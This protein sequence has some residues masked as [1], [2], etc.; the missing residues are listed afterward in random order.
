MITILEES[1]GLLDQ[2]CFFLFGVSLQKEHHVP[3]YCK[4]CLVMPALVKQVPA[5][6]QVCVISAHLTTKAKAWF[7]SLVSSSNKG[8]FDLL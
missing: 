7:S 1:L 6:G 4:S 3:L 5:Y 8:H 2:L